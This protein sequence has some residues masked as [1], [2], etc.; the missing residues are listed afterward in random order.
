MITNGEILED[1]R[2]DEPCPSVLMLGFIGTVPYHVVVAE[3]ED[4]LRLITIYIQRRIDGK[5][6]D[7][8]GEGTIYETEKV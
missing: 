6:I 7:R 3:C 5:I 1:Y 2:N 4:H 8:G